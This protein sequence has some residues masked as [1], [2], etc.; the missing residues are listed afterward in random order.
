MRF[1]LLA[2][3]ALVAASA[4]AL[5]G[6]AGVSAFNSA[7]IPQLKPVDARI[8]TDV[9]CG[10]MASQV[11]GVSGGQLSAPAALAIV[12]FCERR[13][14]TQ[15]LTLDPQGAR[16]VLGGILNKPVT[17]NLPA[18]GSLLPVNP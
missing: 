4:V 6:C 10:D 2:G 16:K 7:L 18:V 11:L 5:S 12:Q 14:A 13:D 15:T 17:S 8:H 3:A 9:S 1:S